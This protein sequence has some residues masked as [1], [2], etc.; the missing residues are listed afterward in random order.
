MRSTSNYSKD[1]YSYEYGTWQGPLGTHFTNKNS[2]GILWQSRT[3]MNPSILWARDS[4]L[5]LKV[6]V[7]RALLLVAGSS[8]RDAATLVAAQVAEHQARPLQQRWRCQ[9]SEGAGQGACWSEKEKKQLILFFKRKKHCFNF[10]NLRCPLL[11]S[12]KKKRI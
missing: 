5:G 6:V 12:Q 10:K 9:A 2:T 4:K 1:N 3:E 8:R 11:N 7:A